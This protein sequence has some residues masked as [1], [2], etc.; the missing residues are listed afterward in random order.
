[1]HPWFKW[2]NYIN[3][4]AYAFEALMVNEFHGREFPCAR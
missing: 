4:L 1:M 3:P 2:L